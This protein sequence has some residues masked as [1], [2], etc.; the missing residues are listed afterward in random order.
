[1]KGRRRTG[2]RGRAG[3]A[4]AAALLAAALPAAAVARAEPPLVPRP[5]VVHEEPGTFR[6]DRRSAIV[7]DAGSRAEARELRSALVRATGLPLPIVAP[8]LARL[9]GPAA[10]RRGPRAI[11][12]T[13]PR[14]VGTVVRLRLTPGARELGPEGYRLR[15]SPRRAEISAGTAAGLFYGGR[16]LLQLLP[17]EVLSTAP[18]A[19]VEWRAPCVEILDRP[20]FRWRGAML[21]VSRHFFPREDVL[22]FLELM[23][24]H[25]LNR[26]HWHLT[27]DQGWRLPVRG[28]PLLTEVGGW[29][30]ESPVRVLPELGFINA[31]AE[32]AVP[33]PDGGP[34][35]DGTPH[36]GSYTQADVRA[37]AARARELH[38]RVVPEIDMPGH[39]SSAIAVHPELGN[40]GEPIEVATTWGIHLDILNAEEATIAFLENVYREVDRLL[41]GDFLHLGGDEVVPVQWRESPRA[42]ERARELGLADVDELQGYLVRRVAAFLRDELGRRPI[43]WSDVLEDGLPTDVGVMSWTSQ[44]PGVEAARAGHP[45][46]MAPIDRTYLDHPQAVSEAA[47][48]FLD[49]LFGQP[50]D[51]TPWITSLEEIYGFEPVPPELEGTAAAGNVLGGQAQLWSEFIE[52]RDELDERAFPR[53]AALAEAVWSAK[54]RRDLGSF[55]SR[56]PAHLA[57][58]D[59]LGV[60]SFRE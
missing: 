29:R 60:R 2:T 28:D 35:F 7:A 17:P 27:D 49:M 30:R 12:Q 18:V 16:T 38:I 51:P 32:L 4:A 11:R 55:R 14:A 13:M 47:R 40:T 31:F 1:M 57:R 10:P 56:L 58:L 48:D 52:S 3:R 50:F 20:R 8:G 45:V 24:L 39:I 26:F 19:G 21:D 5:L 54:A 46:V 6:L 53:L 44:A 36:G 9:A 25:K 23:A 41:P 22:R 43:G 33:G 34:R 37:I 42:I 59:A 15:I